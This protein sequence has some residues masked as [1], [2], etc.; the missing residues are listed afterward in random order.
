MINKII[1]SAETKRKRPRILRWGVTLILAV[2]GI[3]VIRV[4]FLLAITPPLRINTLPPDEEL[5]THFYE[6]RADIEEL[7]RR[8]RNYVPPPG[9]Q[10]G[11][12]RK[13]GDT[14]ELFKRAGV[15]RLIEISPTWLPNPYSLE[16][17]QRDKGIVA[18]WRE[19]AKYRT[20]A[21]R[22]LDTRFYHNVVWKDLV[23][24]P[25]APRIEDGILIGPID[26][27]GRHSHQRVFPTL[28]NEPPDVERDT[29]AYRQIEP[30]WFV[31]MC[32]TL[33]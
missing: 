21:I 26:H 29:C 15:K 19:A 3:W 4:L 10:H 8:Y 32:R 31:Q 11:E 1:Q 12:W 24:M 9:T 23:F 18:N 5:I 16:A 22:P 30:Q 6:H 7:V 25:V 27:L 2:L 17:R 14:P 28:N 20:L 33:Y 13:L